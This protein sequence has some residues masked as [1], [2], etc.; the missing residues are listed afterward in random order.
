MNYTKYNSTTGEITATLVITDLASV[1]ANLSD[2]NWI[3]GSYITDT[4]YIDIETQTPVEKPAKPSNN[5]TWN[6]NTKSWHLDIATFADQLRTQRSWLLSQID[7]VNPI[8]YASLTTDQQTE[9]QAYRT[10]LLNVPQQSGFP[11]NITWP[12][13]PAWL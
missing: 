8:W 6:I 5:H 13:K 7:R 2:S 3:S 10:D 12:S 11:T 4:H 1:A 9:L